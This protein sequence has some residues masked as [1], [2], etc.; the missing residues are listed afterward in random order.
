M[1]WWVGKDAP[2]ARGNRQYGWSFYRVDMIT[3]GDQK[4]KEKKK[5]GH[6]VLFF[7]SSIFSEKLDRVYM[8]CIHAL[9]IVLVS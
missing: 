1:A 6:G 7:S 2:Q 8:Y 4:E 9:S 5:K 3:T